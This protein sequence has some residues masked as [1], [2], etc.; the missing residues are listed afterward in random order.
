MQKRNNEKIKSRELT[1]SSFVHA[2]QAGDLPFLD[3][4]NQGQQD[5]ELVPAQVQASVPTIGTVT[6]TTSACS[7]GRSRGNDTHYARLVIGAKLGRCECPRNTSGCDP[8]ICATAVVLCTGYCVERLDIA[9]WNV[10]RGE[11]AAD[12]IGAAAL[13]ARGGHV[14]GRRVIVI[15]GE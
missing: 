15:V 6:P 11:E 12:Q 4:A 9:L 3:K 10:G 5:V 13:L 7:R 2:V 1:S 8:S 14:P